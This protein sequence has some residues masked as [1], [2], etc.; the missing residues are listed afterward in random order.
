M[1][2]PKTTH[3]SKRGTNI[4][5]TLTS[6]RLWYFLLI[7]LSIIFGSLLLIVPRPEIL[8]ALAIAIIVGLTFF[9]Y[10]YSGILT[11]IILSYMR[12]E[13]TI[14][15]L[16]NLHL[17]RL[18][19]LTLIVVWAIRA[20]ITKS[21]LYFQEKGL[22]LLYLLYLMM[23]FS[24][25]FS[26]WASQSVNIFL[27]MLKILAFVI[28]FIHLI[29]NQKKLKTFFWVFLIVNF[30]LAFSA[31]KNFLSLGQS[32]VSARVGGTGGFLG[33]ANDFALALSIAL[34]FSFYFFLAERKKV[35]KF[36]YLSFVFILSLG[37][38]STSSR[39][40]FITLVFLMFYFV[41]KS[42][43]KLLGFFSI[44]LIFFLIFLFA[45]QDYWQ[46]QM[47][48][49]SY[50]EDESSMGRIE[51]WEAGL[52]MFIDRPF[53]GVGLGAYSVAYGTRY[54]MRSGPWRSAHNAYI[55]TGAELGSFGILFYLGLMF[56][57]YR[58]ANRLTKSIPEENYL[59]S[60]SHGLKGSL[61]AYAVGSFFLSVAHYPHLY[62]LLGMA[63]VVKILNTQ[64]GA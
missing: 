45:P 49:T 40:G 19:T 56:Y 8:P 33:D 30:F 36:I 10:P 11:Y 43:R 41:L 37:I 2:E 14:P 7:F 26:Y 31:V 59:K 21:N 25:P 53:T 57:I 63:I 28:L 15:A 13:E 5:W 22:I 20:A 4:S 6:E 35:L 32:A 16:G 18:L 61:L 46:R 51:A 47:T 44:L 29:D 42:K 34:P 60:I 24:I 38:I 55:Q 27:N 12:F 62:F 17:T 54:S 1:E 3:L 64:K 50:Q 58:Q 48:I 23:V 52:R 9:F 39:G